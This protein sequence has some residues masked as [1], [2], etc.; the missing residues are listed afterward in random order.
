MQTT[1]TSIYQVPVT[2]LPEATTEQKDAFQAWAISELSGCVGVEEYQMTEAE[3]D[4]V[5]GDKAFSGSS[6][7]SETY[8]II[9]AYQASLNLG[10]TL[11]VNA[12]E[13]PLLQSEF[14]QS[15]WQEL[16]VLGEPALLE[17][18]SWN[19]EWKKH[20]SPILV[21][22]FINVVPTWWVGESKEKILK[23]NPGQAFGTG[24]HAT[25]FL[26][27][28]ALSQLS[29]NILPNPRMLD[30]GCGSGILGLAMKMIYPQGHYD[31]VDI[32]DLAM[33]ETR[34]NHEENLLSLENSRLLL[35]QEFKFSSQ[36][37]D[38]IAANILLNTILDFKT[39]LLSSLRPK[40]HL[41]LSGILETQVEELTN[42]LKSTNQNLKI[43]ET[44]QDGWSCIVVSKA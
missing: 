40:G 41:L 12:E 38:I 14:S 25:T 1:P 16:S 29:L 6:V 24:Q 27:L 20:F 26:C 4:A 10:C 23:I 36:A 8:D 21:P 5:L 33:D 35:G 7:D 13:F 3:I 32:E 15:Y 28:Q 22:S 43:Q 31:F 18:K 9:E 44:K 37:Y 19:E 42:A 11:Y 17:N 34:R 39:Q 30:F 2:F